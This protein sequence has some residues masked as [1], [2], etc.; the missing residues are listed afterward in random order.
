MIPLSERQDEYYK[1]IE[2]AI[3]LISGSYEFFSIENNVFLLREL[4]K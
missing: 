4:G 2:E 3:I 1:S